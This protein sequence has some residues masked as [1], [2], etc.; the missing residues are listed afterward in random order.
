MSKAEQPGEI[1]PAPSR[2]PS[3]KSVLPEFGE[4][5]QSD[6][7]EFLRDTLLTTDSTTDRDVL[8]RVAEFVE[9]FPERARLPIST[10]G[11]LR[12]RYVEFVE[13]VWEAE[14]YVEGE[15]SSSEVS[16]LQPE[17]AMCWA[18]AVSLTLQR[19]R[20]ATQT[21]LHFGHE[22]GSAFSVEASNRWKPQYQEKQLA[23]MHG[24]LRQ[25]AGGDYDHVENVPDGIEV[26]GR[27][28]NPKLIL[29]T[30]GASSRPDVRLTPGEFEG[31]MA[32]SWSTVY[33]ATRNVMNSLDADAYSYDARSEPH[34]GKG[35]GINACYGHEHVV[36]V[37]DV[38]RP[39]HEI[40]AE[41]RR[42]AEAHVRATPTAG[43]K[44]HDLDKPLSE[45]SDPAAEIG[46]CEVFDLDDDDCPIDNIAGYV[47]A[48]ASLDAEDGLFERSIEY[49][50][51]AAT[52]DALNTRTMRR[53]EATVE[54][55][56][57][58]LQTIMGHSPEAHAI[59]EPSDGTDADAERDTG[60]SGVS[61]GGL[62]HYSDW[63]GK[64]GRVGTPAVSEV[65]ADAV[66][67]RAGPETDPVE[68]TEKMRSEGWD[69][70][71]DA[72]SVAFQGDRVERVVEQFDAPTVAKVAGRL[73][74]EV[75]P[76]VVELVLGG[77]ELDD[78]LAAYIC[79]QF[80]ADAAPA[81]VARTLS[82]CAEED[83]KV[84]ATTDRVGAILE[85]EGYNYDQ[86]QTV[87]PE[88]SGWSLES[89]TT[90]VG[91]DNEATEEVGGTGGV[92]MVEVET[93]RDEYEGMWVVPPKYIDS[94]A[95]LIDDPERTVVWRYRNGV[96]LGGR[97]TGDYIRENWGDVPMREW[98][99]YVQPHEMGTADPVFDDRPADAGSGGVTVCG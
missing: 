5:S 37:A 53:S 20:S 33:D 45:W 76:Q 6:Q 72:V 15:W 60:E 14:D 94:P 98:W 92:E 44:A 64:A 58:D 32:S 42:V 56:D 52:K 25:S 16:E 62:C 99:R 28:E 13:A 1:R 96:A 63:G 23:K 38:D 78:E 46:T 11:E 18:D 50:A 73:R 95:D 39:I 54:M 4:L 19:Y 81:T 88:S 82:G 68:L 97:V 79:E 43:R 80:D 65:L 86:E 55:A 74:G 67:S 8:V 57:A 36:L 93:D 71:A 61:E 89:I 49:V 70:S 2:L 9:K 59:H 77:F 83:W 47:G 90:G 26:E 21:E 48:Y 75:D 10:N 24:W 35:Y 41:F 69:V 84:E 7:I 27:Y 91:T 17:R 29:L 12:S 3:T 66:R 30:R 34:P 87:F 85:C 22:D 40:R 31:D 51:W